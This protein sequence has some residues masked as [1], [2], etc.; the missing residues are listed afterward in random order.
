MGSSDCT[1]NE[2]TSTTNV[3]KGHIIINGMDEPAPLPNRHNF[4]ADVARLNNAITKISKEIGKYWTEERRTECNI[5][6]QE[7]QQLKQSF[8]YHKSQTAHFEVE[9]KR[10][11]GALDAKQRELH[12]LEDSDLTYKNP[13]VAKD[14]LAQLE[15]KYRNQTFSSA[16]EEQLIINEIERHKRNVSKLA[17]YMPILEECKR[18]EGLCKIAR[19]THR[20]EKKEFFDTRDRWKN[21]RT[22]LRKIHDPIFRFRNKLNE[23]RAE[24]KVMINKYEKERSNYT[25]WLKNH[26]SQGLASFPAAILHDHHDELEPF[27]EKK[28]V[29][30]RLISYLNKLQ[31]SVENTEISKELLA[32]VHEAAA[33]IV[34]PPPPVPQYSFESEDSADDYPPGFQQLNLREADVD[35]IIKNSSKRRFNGKKNLKKQNMPITHGIEYI[36]LF[37]DL[38]LFPPKTYSEVQEALGKVKRVLEFYEEQTTLTA[39]EDHGLCL[40]PIPS[41]IS[42]SGSEFFDSP[43][44]SPH[45]ISSTSLFPGVEPYNNGESSSR[46]ES[47]SR[48]TNMDS[49][50]NSC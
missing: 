24:K 23:F 38:D 27:Y 43:L 41:V 49:S 12:D 31:A 46:A 33:Q 42:M 47:N 7:E 44:L 11:Q 8:I 14:K 48:F 32:E 36:K 13:A 21:T 19:N 50:R 16:R 26:R 18:L 45:S 34:Q 2:S 9:L 20:N 28:Q 25:Q 37:G 3:S 39:T 1:L 29:C 10:A 17:K 4:E 35:P 15:T 5:L 22:R 40:S 6:K 30:Q